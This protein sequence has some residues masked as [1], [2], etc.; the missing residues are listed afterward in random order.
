MRTNNLDMLEEKRDE[1]TLQTVAYKHKTAKYYNLQ[2]KPRRFAV[3]DLVLKK[4]S[5]AT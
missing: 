2:V 4:V 5:L 1:A 3:G